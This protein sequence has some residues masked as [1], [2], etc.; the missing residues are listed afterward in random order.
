MEAQ[1]YNLLLGVRSI[2]SIGSVH[3]VTNTGLVGRTYDGEVISE[4]DVVR[5]LKGGYS[6]LFLRSDGDTFVFLDVFY[7]DIMIRVFK[8][9]C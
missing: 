2:M 8:R 6:P 7:I 9:R 4:G 3:F 1:N 5:Y